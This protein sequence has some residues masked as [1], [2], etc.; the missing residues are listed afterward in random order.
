MPAKSN[1]AASCLGPWLNCHPRNARKTSS[2]SKLGGIL[3]DRTSMIET[4]DSNKGCHAARRLSRLGYKEKYDA[5]RL[6]ATVAFTRILSLH[7]R[8]ALSGSG[9]CP[10]PS[11]RGVAP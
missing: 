9:Q 1:G 3:S 7:E 2:T 11:L 8:E 6:R 4:A 10:A 5:G